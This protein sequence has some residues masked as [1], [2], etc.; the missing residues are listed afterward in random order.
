MRRLRADG[1]TGRTRVSED[2]DE[3][4]GEEDDAPEEDGGGGVDSW[5]RRLRFDDGSRLS[6]RPIG[7]A[8]QDP[9]PSCPKILSHV[10]YY[11]LVSIPNGTAL[12]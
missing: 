3:D 5:M 6:P 4:Q 12:G 7:T 2:D 8:S 11:S 9:V 1:A 10:D